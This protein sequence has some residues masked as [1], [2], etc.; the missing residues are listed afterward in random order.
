MY[1]AL[2]GDFVGSRFEFWPHK[3]REFDLLSESCRPTDDTVLTIA[4]GDALAHGLDM[5][6]TLRSY[7]Q[8]FPAS[9]GMHFRDW[10]Y[11]RL[12]SDG[13]YG[14]W[15]NGAAMRVSTAAWLAKD[16]DECMEMAERSAMVTH[17]H[18]EAVR[19]A[20][21]VAAAIY[22]GLSGWHRNDIKSF[23]ERAFGYDLSASVDDL[24][25]SSYFEL[26]SWISIPKALTCAFE[27]ETVEAAIRNAVYL[28]G[29]A[30][31]EAAI[32]GSIAET[33]SQPPAEVIAAVMD[34]F[35]KS[36][37]LR[38]QAI[39]AKMDQVQRT[40]LTHAEADRVVPWDPSV[41]EE[42]DRKQRQLAEIENAEAEAKI[43]KQIAKLNGTA[44]PFVVEPETTRG[45][46][47]RFRRWLNWF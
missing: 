46:L 29:D 7:T 38:V 39:K 18:P 11:G 6:K 4:V 3:S 12:A 21:A 45:V 40:P 36:L 28:G 16:F 43:R 31:T 10:A 24:M 30:D 19:S 5:A 22:A 44:D 47:T 41:L 27:A 17:N 33:W 20:K 23:V 2:A 42:W 1:G 15:G 34:Y 25:P 35:P 26:K 13:P 32:A 8:S 37:R 9:Y 14:S